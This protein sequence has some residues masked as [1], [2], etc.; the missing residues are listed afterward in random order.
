MNRSRVIVA[1]LAVPLAFALAGCADPGSE[2][3][4]DP[5]IRFDWDA[6][7]PAQLALLT[8]TLELND[9]CLTG[10]G[11]EFI[12][13]PR[14]LAEWDAATET[15]TYGGADFEMGDT[16]NAGG[17]G[18]SLPDDAT[19]PAACGLED[20]QAVFMIQTTSLS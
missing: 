5:I 18:G 10:A 17:G 20:G 1:A 12:A 6:D 15:L 16:I 7:G 8:T 19:I 3:A 2:S 9:G 11:G 13:F 14:D 4:D